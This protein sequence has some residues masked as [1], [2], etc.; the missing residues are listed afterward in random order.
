[1]KVK[2]S[3]A[4]I[5]Q[6]VFEAFVCDKTVATVS[7]KKKKKQLPL[8]RFHIMLHSKSFFLILWQLLE[9]LRKPAVPENNKKCQKSKFIKNTWLCVFLLYS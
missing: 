4:V 2:S 1:M 5:Y 7:K 8:S 9:L 6:N 3:P